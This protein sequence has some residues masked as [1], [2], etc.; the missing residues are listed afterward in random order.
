[1]SKDMYISIQ[2]NPSV[3]RWSDYVHFNL[4][5]LRLRI[6]QFLDVITRK[7][8]KRHGH[9][10]VCSSSIYGFWLPLWYLQTLLKLL[11]RQ[12]LYFCY[13]KLWEWWSTI[14]PTSTKRAITSQAIECKRT[15][16][17]G[18]GNPGHVLGQAQTSGDHYYWNL[19]NCFELRR[20][21]K[22]YRKTC[23]VKMVWNDGD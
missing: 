23:N 14:P 9:C 1:M 8:S 2:W 10:V 22:C 20:Q 19:V 21:K 3:R 18:V 13:G 4:W 6:L 7:C 15:K 16:T 17:C 12:C 5:T 11:M